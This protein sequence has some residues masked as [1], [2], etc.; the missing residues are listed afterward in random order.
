MEAPRDISVERERLMDEFRAYGGTFTEFS[1]R[2]A[3]W[4]GLHTTDATA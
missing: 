3:S 2:F 1:H 4:L